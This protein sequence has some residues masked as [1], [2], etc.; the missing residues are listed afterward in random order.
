MNSLLSQE[1]KQLDAGGW[2]GSQWKGEQIPLLSEVIPTVPSGRK[3]II[4]IKPGKVF[5][6]ELIRVVNQSGLDLNQI[7]F[8]S[9][10]PR[11]CAAIKKDFPTCKV[12]LL[13]EL[14]YTWLHRIFRPSTNKLIDIVLNYNLDG[15]NLWAGNMIDTGLIQKCYKHKL[16]LYTWTTNSTGKAIELSDIGVDGITTDRVKSIKE[17]LDAYFQLA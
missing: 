1:L 17:C 8:I 4:E 9:F 11:I 10:D 13:S 5:M 6:P 15:L 16:L 2:E 14:D 12:L 7:E 3:L